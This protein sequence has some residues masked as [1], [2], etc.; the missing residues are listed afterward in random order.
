ER[1]RIMTKRT[2]IATA[3]LLATVIVALVVVVA[4]TSGRGNE[5]TQPE[6]HGET[7]EPHPQTPPAGT[8]AA[9]VELDAVGRQVV[10]PDNPGG[11][12]LSTSTDDGGTCEDIRSPA[13][14]QIQRVHGFP[15]LFSTDSGPTRISDE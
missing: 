2:W 11:D 4:V 13:D 7:S 15:V 9:G 12:V 1:G 8:P 3:A 5:T 6:T 10:I 14:V